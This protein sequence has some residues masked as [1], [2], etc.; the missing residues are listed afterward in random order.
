MIHFLSFL[1]G[2][3]VGVH[4]V[5]VA[6]TGPVTRVEFRLDGKIAAEVSKPPWQAEIDLGPIL[7]PA[8]LE[9][10][11]FDSEGRLIGRDHQ[12]V[13]LPRPRAEA[14]LVPRV[15]S[16]GKISGARLQWNSAEF[17]KPKHVEFQLD[18]KHIDH[19]SELSVDLRGADPST[20]HILD[21]EV[22]FP[23]Q[24]VVRE[25]LVFG[26]GYAGNLSLHLTAVPILLNDPENF[27]PDAGLKGWFEAKGQ[28]IEVAEVEKGNAQL[29]VVRGSS[30]DKNLEDLEVRLEK[31]DSQG[32][33]DRL[34]DDVFFRVIGTVP[35]GGPRGNARLFPFS[36]PKNVGR[37]GLADEL[38]KA[39]FGDLQFGLHRRADAVALAGLQAAAGNQRRAVLLILGPDEDDVSTHSAEVVKS[40]LQS[41]RVPLIVFD[42]S[43]N[44][45]A[46]EAWRPVDEVI[47]PLRW[48]SSVGWLQEDL[49]NQRIVWLMG[50]HLPGDIT[51]GAHAQGIELVQ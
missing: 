4:P 16:R 2:L 30:A 33:T 10:V 41:L 40:Y 43:G 26:K 36:D 13:N 11:A 47:D 8:L 23:D 48:L 45:P 22:Q 44:S 20:L 7:R 17:L 1:V 21:T 49:D 3:V 39:R 35:T 9:S 31:A 19:D 15:D 27:P 32:R 37:K 18:G 25:Q 14:V 12:W 51:L 28:P 34:S 6:V 24:V 42:V 46:A 38:E 29:V 50:R 5:Q